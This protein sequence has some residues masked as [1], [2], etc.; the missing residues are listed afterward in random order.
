MSFLNLF[1]SSSPI[2]SNSEK[3]DFLL[4]FCDVAV[5][6]PVCNDG[7]VLVTRRVHSKTSRAVILTEVTVLGILDWALM[8]AFTN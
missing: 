5:L 2:E 3:D 1:N 4:P 8:I 7:T 6:S